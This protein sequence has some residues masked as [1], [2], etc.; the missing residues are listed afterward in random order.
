MS[1]NIVK[2]TR[3]R[4]E[5]FQ[6]STVCLAGVQPKMGAT[7]CSVTGTVKHIR[8]D[9]PTNPTVIRLLVQPDAGGDLVTVDPNH[10]KAILD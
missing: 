10:V 4:A 1:H 5:W 7:A 8:G 6:A 9:H 3:I 2:G